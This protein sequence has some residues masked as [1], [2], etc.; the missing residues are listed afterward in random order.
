MRDV[1]HLR[2]IV[3]EMTSKSFI[4]NCEIN[5]STIFNRCLRSSKV[6][7]DNASCI[8]VATSYQYRPRTRHISTKFHRFKDEIRKGNLEVVKVDTK[9]NW[10]D[11]FTKPLNAQSLASIR[12]KFMGW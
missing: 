6:F 7:E 3:T 11:I 8:V 9:E 1:L 5:G 2:R 4:Q 10:A 12:S